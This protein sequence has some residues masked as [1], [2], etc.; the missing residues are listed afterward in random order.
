[1]K[2]KLF[3]WAMA[4]MMVLSLA[5]C[6]ENEKKQEAIDA[7]NATANTFNETANL[8]NANLDVMDGE[9]VSVCQEMSAV[10]SE[11]TTLLEGDTELTD[12]AYDEMIAWFADA[13]AWAADSKLELETALAEAEAAAQAEAEAAAQESETATSAVADVV[14]GSW[15]LCG[16]LSGG[17][18]W[19]EADLQSTL[20]MYGGTLQFVFQED[21]TAG[22]VQGGGIL[23]GTFEVINEEGIGAI[24]DNN[25]TELRYICQF[26]DM[27]GQIVMLVTV[28]QEDY[29]YFLPI[30]EY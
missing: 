6:G 25:G 18:E 20:E 4:V 8:I 11:Y 23:N 29:M 16:G 1:M 10:L 5:A 15:E 30:S 3:T 13:K 17:V 21:G 26:A 27:E 24:F 19:E 14:L 2:K 22:M 28:D 7:F 12:E 9:V